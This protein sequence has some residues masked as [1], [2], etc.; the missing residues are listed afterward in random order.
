MYH[1]GR[2]QIEAH[3]TSLPHMHTQQSLT[4][5]VMINIKMVLRQIHA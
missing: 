4:I 5:L 2:A 3:Q 1:H